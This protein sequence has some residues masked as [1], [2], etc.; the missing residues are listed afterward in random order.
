M[1]EIKKSFSILTATAILA[2]GSIAVLPE[3]TFANC[4]MNVQA[5]ESVASGECGE[6]LTWTLD[7]AGTL[8]I[9]G[10]GSMSYWSSSSNV[11]WYSYREQIAN[12]IIENDVTSIGTYAFYDCPSLTSITIPDSV[13]TIGD[14]AFNNCAKLTSITIPDS[15][16]SIGSGVF[17][18]CKGLTTVTIP[19]SVV[20]IGSNAFY[21]C[22]GL[23]SITFENPECEI[24]DSKFAISDTATI[25]GYAGS[26][27]QA[28]AEKYNRKFI[29]LEENTYTKG[30]MNDDDQITIEDAQIVLLAY[31]DILA[32][33]SS[34][35]T[36]A[37]M[38]AADV[39]EDGIID[40]LDAQYILIY[41][42]ETVIAG[43]E[44]TWDSIIVKD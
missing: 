39:N 34:T 18:S 25:Y 43:K 14:S 42:V 20:S 30:N 31:S 12:V 8:R 7:S 11:P 2:T 4:M 6:N 32:G 19:D 16:I 44:I 5:A 28:Y 29:A 21:S 15:V 1:K 27:A 24:Y 38:K 41:Y 40:V 35:L 37:Q 10:Q 22:K 23:N 36:P 33:G 3:R 26:T 13:T 9:S 17:S